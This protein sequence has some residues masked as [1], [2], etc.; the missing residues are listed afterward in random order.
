MSMLPYFRQYGLAEPVG[1]Y[2]TI[3]AFALGDPNLTVW[4]HM[5]R[6]PE[7]MKNFMV[8]MEVMSK[9]LPTTG[10][11]DYSWV[12]D[13][14]YSDRTLVVDVGGGKGHALD[15]IVKATPG[16]PMERCAVED[17]DVVVTEAKA[18]AQGALSHAQFVTADFHKEQPIKSKRK[19][20]HSQSTEYLSNNTDRRLDILHQTL[21]P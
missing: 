3:N 11:Y 14:K 1:L 16:L 18:I 20:I 19:A 15:A 5:N 7:K 6:N 4:E 12:I 9:Q 13:D 17:L 10:S 8:A 21:S 2:N